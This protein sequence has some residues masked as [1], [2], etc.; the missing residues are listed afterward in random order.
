[1]ARR[2]PVAT[3]VMRASYRHANAARTVAVLQAA[4]EDETVAPQPG[5][6]RDQLKSIL[7]ARTAECDAALQALK[8]LQSQPR[9]QLEQKF[10]AE[11]A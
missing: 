7:I 9:W 11:K 8:E 4:M 10:A 3:L 6:K 1:M 5:A 2:D